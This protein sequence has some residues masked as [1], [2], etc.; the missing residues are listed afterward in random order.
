MHPAATAGIHFVFICAHRANRCPPYLTY[1]RNSS[2]KLAGGQYYSTVRYNR[3]V[4][5]QQP[6]TLLLQKWRDGDRSAFDHLFSMVY[7]E[8]RRM[9]G[10]YLKQEPHG[11]TLQPTALVHEAYLRLAGN[12]Q[13]NFDDRAHFFGVSARVMRQILVDHARSRSAEK[14]GGGNARIPLEEG[15]TFA[16]EQASTVLA[17]DEALVAL[18]KQDPEKARILEMR[19]FAGMTAEDS[20]AVLGLSVHQVNRQ[21][22]LARAWLRKEMAANETS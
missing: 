12:E 19:F 13:P 7:G 20:A 9:A 14:R 6:V 15:T 21:M 4:P 16:V 22:R 1:M 10:A 18:E 11:H 3:A 8:L 17:L 2:Q 5:E